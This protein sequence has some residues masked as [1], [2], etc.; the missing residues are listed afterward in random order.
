MRYLVW[1]SR[2]GCRTQMWAVNKPLHDEKCGRFSL[3][4]GGKVLKNARYIARKA[5]PPGREGAYSRSVTS[6]DGRSRCGFPCA[7]RRW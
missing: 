3:F 4:V 2:D 7:L 5:L 1:K 6:P